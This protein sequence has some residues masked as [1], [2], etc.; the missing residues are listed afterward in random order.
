MVKDQPA[1]NADGKTHASSRQDEG[2][3]V[4]DQ[5]VYQ[6]DFKIR[7]AVRLFVALHN[8]QLR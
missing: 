7:I 1:G 4:K 6:Q 3:L 8:D 2:E 5:F